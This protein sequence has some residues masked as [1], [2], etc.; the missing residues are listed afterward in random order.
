MIPIPR[1]IGLRTLLLMSLTWLLMSFAAAVNAQQPAVRK[2]VDKTGKHELE[3]KFAGLEGQEVVLETAD[4][5]RMKIKLD[6]LSFDDQKYALDQSAKMKTENPFKESAGNPSDEPSSASSVPAGKVVTVRWTAAKVLNPRT[7]PQ[8]WKVELDPEPAGVPRAPTAISLPKKRDFFEGFSGTV[9]NAGEGLVCVAHKMDRG[10]NKDTRIEIVD[11]N[12]GKVVREAVLENCWRPLAVA[13]G[14]STLV[15]RSDD[16]GFG[17]KERLT[18][19]KLNPDKTSTPLR[20]WICS[21]ARQGSARDIVWAEG[22]QQGRLATLTSDGRLTIW[23]MNTG[24]VKA[25]MDMGRDAHVATTP[26][27][28]FL[29]CGVG[30][31]LVAIDATRTRLLG[32]LTIPEAAN[33][34]AKVSVRPDGTKFAFGFGSVIHVYDMASG[35]REQEVVGVSTFGDLVWVDDANLLVGS[36]GSRVLINLDHGFVVWTYTGIEDALRLGPNTWFSFSSTNSGG[37]VGIKMPRKD[38]RDAVDRALQDPNFFALTQGRSAKIDVSGI[39][40]AGEQQKALESLTGKMQANGVTVD[41]GAPVTI[42][43]EVKR[44][45]TRKVEF[46]TFGMFAFQQGDVRDITEWVSA[47]RIKEGDKLIWEAYS[48]VFP[49]YVSIQEGES[50]DQALARMDK[51]DHRFFQ[52]IVIPRNLPREG[53]RGGLGTTNLGEG[54]F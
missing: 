6:L 26:G 7:A 33:Q 40:D 50:L 39:T 9:S 22:L 1:L 47:L 31:A 38:A 10:S 53:G 18:V 52:T 24:E 13:D 32:S 11:L 49:N 35:R 27:G 19:W 3:G 17:G 51:P 21:Q 48:T 42:E 15:L 25:Y 28:R 46:R 16:F 43:A 45:V 12:A 4:G 44:G 29:L 14:G 5:K 37:L 34:S 36:G 20:G 30:S 8:D 41:P 54:T 23:D 2:W